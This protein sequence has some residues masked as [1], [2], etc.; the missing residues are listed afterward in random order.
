MIQLYL[1]KNLFNGSEEEF[2]DVKNF[3]SKVW[4][5]NGELHRTGGPAV[6]CSDGSE[7]WHQ[8]GDLHRTDGPAMIL[9][10]GTKR[11]YQNGIH[12]RTDD[13]AVIWG[14]E[15]YQSEKYISQITFYK[16]KY[17]KLKQEVDLITAILDS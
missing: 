16:S 6:I 8:N 10:D 2:I 13:P 17:E 11:W 5:L 4:R 7:W 12:Y 14:G 9:K 15:Y 3:S 1:N